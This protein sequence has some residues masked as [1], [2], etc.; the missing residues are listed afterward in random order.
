[1]EQNVK[2]NNYCEE[3][4]IVPVT[5]IYETPDAYSLKMEM[6]GVNKE[7][8][9]ITLENNE[10]EVSGKVV[11][12]ESDARNLKYS[13]YE[14]LDYYRKFRVGNDIDRNSIKAELDNG[15]LTLTLHK[16]E[17]VKPKKIQIT[18]S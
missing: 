13:E 18:A 2:T 4:V 11:K 3:C 14:L 17:E 8:V 10:L 7:D 16:S 1:M 6:P 5:D 15:I 9:N 12:D